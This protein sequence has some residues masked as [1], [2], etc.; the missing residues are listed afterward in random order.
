MMKSDQMG[1]YCTNSDGWGAYTGLVQETQRWACIS[2]T[3]YVPASTYKAGTG[4]S[5]V[6]RILVLV[7]L[8]FN[9]VF[10]L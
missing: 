10:G 7:M 9:A 2:G 1:V 8:L 4:G 6:N 5:T 3:P